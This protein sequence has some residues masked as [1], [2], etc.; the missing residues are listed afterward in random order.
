VISD[1]VDSVK[2][3]IAR[4]DAAVQDAEMRQMK[5]NRYDVNSYGGGAASIPDL[6][7]VKKKKRR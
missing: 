3:G 4:Q 1:M 7:V 6:C 2:R 5:N